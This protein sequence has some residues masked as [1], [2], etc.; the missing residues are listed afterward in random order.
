MPNTSM[1][2]SLLASPESERGRWESIPNNRSLTQP[3]TTSARPPRARTSW[4]MSATIGGVGFMSVATESSL[5]N[6]NSIELEFG[7]IG[8]VEVQSELADA[9]PHARRNRNRMVGVAA[10]I[11]FPKAAEVAAIDLHTNRF[12]G[13]RRRPERQRSDAGR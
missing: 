1:S 9:G 8:A 5:P 7:R 11:R 2:M 6:E 12:R 3:P 4:A 13:G 10:G